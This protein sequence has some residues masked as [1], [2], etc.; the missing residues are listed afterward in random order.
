[1]GS[2]FYNIHPHVDANR[3]KQQWMEWKPPAVLVMNSR[4]LALELQEMRPEAK[5]IYRCT[6]DDHVKDL[7]TPK[8][9]L[10]KMEWLVP[11]KR[12]ILYAG[13]EIHGDPGIPE[14]TLK[15]M[16][17]ASDAG[18]K[19][20]ILNCGT[21]GPEDEEW[22]GGMHP[23][24]PPGKL[25]AWRVGKLENVA[26]KWAKSEHFL[27]L[28]EY[29]DGL[30]WRRDRGWQVGRY[31]RHLNTFERMG[32]T[33]PRDELRKRLI[34]TEATFDSVVRSE[35]KGARWLP[36]ANA[37]R[38][39][40]EMDTEEYTGIPVLMYCIGHNSDRQW[41]MFRLD[42]GQD[43]VVALDDWGAEFQSIVGTY[44]INTKEQEN[45]ETMIVRVT[46]TTKRRNGPG[47]AA[48]VIGTFDVGTY[49]L[50]VG[51]EQIKDGYAWREFRD[52][53]RNLTWWS[54]TGPA[55]DTDAWI[56]L[57]SKPKP[58]PE[59]E[60]E[61]EPTPES[62]PAAPVEALIDLYERQ[63]AGLELYRNLANVIAEHAAFA[64]AHTQELIDDIQIVIDGLEE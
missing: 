52:E 13:N 4:D 58:E 6:P 17:M 12:I 8:L 11:D 43:E 14:W 46:S 32:I 34:I 9:W 60:P 61:P 33:V 35:W 22:W 20:C 27:G 54:A 63:I 47:T 30:D 26:R 49:E 62:K 37:A 5:V 48:Q 36:A 41:R 18:R 50:L 57:T 25:E 10:A 40:I 7:D 23:T 2:L 59:P 21:G 39:M 64:A 51:S 24:A 45:M 3:I 29:A 53:V 31:R 38:Q 1:M 19:L 56:T 44:M 28:H 55:S 15:A 42:Y 16:D